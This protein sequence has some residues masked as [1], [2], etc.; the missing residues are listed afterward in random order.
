MSALHGMT[1][2]C[3]VS[4]NAI[5]TLMEEWAE[6]AHQFVRIAAPKD[7]SPIGLDSIMDNLPEAEDSLSN[8]KDL[9]EKPISRQSL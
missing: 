1:Q 5:S 4:H 9:A 6:N 7:G 3:R 8:R 2:R